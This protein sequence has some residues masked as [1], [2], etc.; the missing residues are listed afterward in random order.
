M[1][2]ADD[3]RSEIAHHEMP[4]GESGIEDARQSNI[5]DDVPHSSRLCAQEHQSKRARR[6]SRCC[7]GGEEAWIGN[8]TDPPSIRCVHAFD[9][10]SHDLTCITLCLPVDSP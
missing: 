1:G 6:F 10:S 9:V 5:A 7:D 2:A 4:C 3:A 8:S